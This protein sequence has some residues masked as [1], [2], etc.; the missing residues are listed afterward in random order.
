MYTA[1]PSIVL[2]D[3]STWYLDWGFLNPTYACPL[4]G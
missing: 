2:A 3:K 4:Y 1:Q